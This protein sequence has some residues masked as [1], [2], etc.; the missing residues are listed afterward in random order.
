M[1]TDFD[2]I[3]NAGVSLL[4]DLAG[5]DFTHAGA[6]YRGNFRTG[7]SLEQAE[8]G[9]FSSHGGQSR[10]VLILQVARSRFSAVPLAWKNQKI[11]RKTPTPAEYTVSSVNADDPNLFSFVL[12]GRA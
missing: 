2:S 9:A 1:A 6:T 5:D 12:I 10:A 4:E 7:T 8:A 3:L 11:Q